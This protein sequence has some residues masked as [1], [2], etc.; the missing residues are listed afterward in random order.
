MQCLIAEILSELCSSLVRATDQA[1]PQQQVQKIPLHLWFNTFHSILWS[2]ASLVGLFFFFFLAY[3]VVV[4]FDAEEIS[5]VAECHRGVCFEAEIWV[6]VSWCQVA[7]L[8]GT[9]QKTKTQEKKERWDTFLTWAFQHYIRWMEWTQTTNLDSTS[10]GSHCY[11]PIP[12]LTHPGYWIIGDLVM[13]SSCTRTHGNQRLTLFCLETGA[14][15]GFMS[16]TNTMQ[17][18]SHGSVRSEKDPTQNIKQP[19]QNMIFFP[20]WLN[21]DTWYSDGFRHRLTPFCNKHPRGTPALHGTK[22]A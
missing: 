13:D 3:Q 15:S 9:S 2:S 11:V 14:Y 1:F 8:A 10:R 17:H 4:W 5:E 19:K 21:C 18:K 7:P 6:V 22:D 20:P 12:L 16:F